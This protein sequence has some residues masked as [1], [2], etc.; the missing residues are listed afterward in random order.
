MTFRSMSGSNLASPCSSGV[1]SLL[2]PPELAV[3]AGRAIP[4]QVAE[5]KGAL[6]HPAVWSIVATIQSVRGG[7]LSRPSVLWPLVTRTRC[8]PW[9]WSS[10]TAPTAGGQHRHQKP[11][12]S[13]RPVPATATH[14]GLGPRAHPEWSSAQTSRGTDM[15][16][17]ANEEDEG[18]RHDQPTD[19]R[20]GPEC[21]WTGPAP[22]AA[23]RT[24]WADR[25][26]RTGWNNAPR[27]APRSAG[28][29]A[30]LTNPAGRHRPAPRRRSRPSV[31]GGTPR[32][33]ER[34]GDGAR[35][36]ARRPASAG[37]GWP[38]DRLPGGTRR[39]R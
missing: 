1:P 39:R 8:R 28:M 22:L 10:A 30:S 11:P 2:P 3:D 16:T 7:P 12:G 9:P 24:E 4:P 38:A 14:S 13:H 17:S 20:H 35:R 37:T 6:L 27:S 23:I 5:G 34:S 15:S 32:R 25:V 29:A 21:P 36:R 33:G 18:G 31:D 26:A 19:G